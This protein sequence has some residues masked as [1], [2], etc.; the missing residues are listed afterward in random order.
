MT[1]YALDAERCAA[2]LIVAFALAGAC[3]VAWL[4]SPTSRRWAWP[5]DRGREYRGRRLFGDNKTIRGFLVM[6]PATGLA[7]LLVSA[8]T[9]GRVSGLWPLTPV[10]Y[11]GVGLLAGLGFMAGELPN[12][13]VKR[14]LG[15]RPGAPA[16]GTIS[17][18][19]FGVIDRLDS[20]LGVLAALAV[21]LPIPAATVVYVLLV[22]SLVHGSF[23]VLTFRMGGKARAA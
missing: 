19:L 9:V 2:F 8:L 16:E 15:I 4:A 13:F 17:G 3:Q 21:V 14:Q 18:P 6:V 11:A 22:G 10:A 1:A 20:P 5:I 23:S 7:F 12:S